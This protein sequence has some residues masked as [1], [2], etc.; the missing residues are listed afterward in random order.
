MEKTNLAKNTILLSIGTVMTKSINLLMIPLFSAWLST[1]DYGMFDLLVTYVSLLIPFITMSGSDAIFRFAIDK[2]KIEDK[3]KYITTGFGITLINTAAICGVILIIRLVTGW[4]Y[5]I[6]FI[7]LLIAELFNNHLQGVIRAIR[8]LTIYSLSNIISTLGISVCVSILVWKYQLG[9]TGIILGYAWGYFLGEIV[10][11]VSVRYWKYLKPDSFSFTI[12]KE[13]VKYSFPLIPNN[14]SWWIINVSDRTAIHLFLGAAAN[15]IYAI[16]YKIPNFCAS[17]FNVFSISWQETA[18]DLIDSKERNQY[19]SYVYNSLICTLVSLCGG[20][21]SLNYFLF[22]Y[23]FDIRYYDAKYYSPILISSV[24]FG[25]MTQYFGGIQISLKRTKENGVTTMIGAVANVVIDLVLIKYIGLYAAALSTITANII[26]CV[27]RYIWLHGENIHFKL[28]KRSLFF[29]SY[30][31]YLFVM[32]YACNSL[33][34]SVINLIFACIM[35]C[36]INK[37]FVAKFFYKVR[38]IK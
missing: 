14:I 9:L 2:D 7:L 33:K 28:E 27:L 34:V 30:Y 8:R 4:A 32:C 36:V 12:V 19:Y 1:E 6:P 35:F 11:V 29:I 3:Q 38:V 31:I 22:Q 15:G 23:I 17:I 13:M 26:V 18:I 37:D 5:A 25:S 20:L 21:L 24:I 10:M 16:S